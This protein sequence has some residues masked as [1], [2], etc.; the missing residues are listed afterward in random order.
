MNT[1]AT[2]KRF[3]GLIYMEPR[4][5]AARAAVRRLRLIVLASWA[6]TIGTLL[7]AAWGR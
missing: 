1:Y 6:V 5:L 2:E 4:E 3:N 7:W